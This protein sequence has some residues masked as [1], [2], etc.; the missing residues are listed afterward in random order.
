MMRFTKIKALAR[1][2][3][4]VAAAI[5][6]LAGVMVGS[7]YASDGVT[8]QIVYAADDVTG[9]VV[10][11]SDD[12]LGLTSSG[13]VL[14]EAT[15]GTVLYEKNSTA[16]LALA[17][18]TKIMT[19]LLIFDALDSGQISLTDEVTVS[20]HASSMG[21]SQVYLEP[22]EV[23]TVDTMIKCIAMASA[24]D[25]CVS[26]AEHIAGTEEAFVEKMNERAAELGMEQ[27]HFVN[28]CGLDADGHMSSA[29]D[30]AVMSRE[31]I[32]KYPAITDYTTVW[33]DTI[34]H[35]TRHGSKDFGLTNTNKLIKQYEWATGLKTGST[36]K[37]GCC[38]SATAVK[39]GVELI[40]VVMD[41]TNSK[42]RFSEAAALLNYGFA[43]CHIYV[44]DGMYADGESAI[45]YEISGSIEKNGECVPEKKFTYIFTQN[46]DESKISRQIKLLPELATPIAAGDY[47]GEIVYSYDGNEMG[48][49]NLIAN[50]SIDKATFT[51][52]YVYVLDVFLYK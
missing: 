51:D 8:E 9:Q 1:A 35:T 10:Y 45:P 39:D 17:S 11:A 30:V 33:M 47:V 41:A 27:T 14:M 18:I 22:M 38:I 36:S 7:V 46:Y 32:T 48:S 42:T 40:A 25:A 16:Q 26:M 29:M 23:Q 37:A 21:G 20:E 44:D 52:V 13:A 15:T 19:L 34:T 12:V 3:L 49:I 28:S 50:D 43:N 24:N 4:G 6:I 31:L 5:C 2:G